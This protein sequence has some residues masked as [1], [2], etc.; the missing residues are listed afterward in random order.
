MGSNGEVK[1]TDFGCCAQLHTSTAKRQTS[2]GTPYWM[3]PEA[4]KGYVAYLN[5][6]D[7]YII[8]HSCRRVSAP[9]SHFG[10]FHY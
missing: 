4:I 1:L 9:L 6:D 2:I 5:V 3:S 7:V 10:V 8:C